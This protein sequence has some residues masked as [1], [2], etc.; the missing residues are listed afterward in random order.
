MLK[1]KKFDAFS[2]LVGVSF[3]VLGR[4]YMVCLGM[5]VLMYGHTSDFV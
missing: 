3:G 4:F 2:L 1:G 5:A